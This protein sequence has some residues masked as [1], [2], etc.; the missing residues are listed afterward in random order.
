M[1]LVDDRTNLAKD[2]ISSIRT[3]YGMAIRIFDAQIPVA[4]RAAE[5]AKAGQSIFT[6]DADGKAAKAYE[7]LTKEVIHDAERSRRRDP[8]SI[9]R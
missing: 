1:T 3:H 2:V 8:V 6:Y 5:A 9:T 7:T 4:V